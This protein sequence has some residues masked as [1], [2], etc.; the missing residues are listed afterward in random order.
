VA[1]PTYYDIL[2]VTRDA[3]AAKIREAYLRRARTLHPDSNGGRTD[4]EATRSE[5]DLRRVNEAWQA[6]KDPERRGQYDESLEPTGSTAQVSPPPPDGHFDEADFDFATDDDTDNMVV[7]PGVAMLLRIGPALLLGVVL[8]GLLI[9]TAVAGRGGDDGSDTRPDRC[10]RVSD[11]GAVVAAC[12][13]ADGRIVSEV[14]RADE[15]PV[16]SVAFGSDRAGVLWC[17]EMTS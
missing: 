14:N 15:C 17:V 7:S 5:S 16:L 6:L 12:G 13:T 8:F 1:A 4:A 9:V 11:D 3:S 10:V 2:G